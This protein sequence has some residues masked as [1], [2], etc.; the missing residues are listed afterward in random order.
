M[1][2]Q[3]FFLQSVNVTVKKKGHFIEAEFF[4]ATIDF[5]GERKKIVDNGRRPFC[6]YPRGFKF[7]R[8][9]EEKIYIE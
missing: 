9:K 3:Q 6:S 8:Q 5:W 2:T 4:I 1:M 7:Q